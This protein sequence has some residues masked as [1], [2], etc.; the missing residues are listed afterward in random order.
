MASVNEYLK[1]LLYQYDCV[2]VPEL[3]AFLTHYQSASFTESSS[4][5][6]PPASALP[7]TRLCGWTMGFWQTT[8]CCTS[9]SPARARNGTS[10]CL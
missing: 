4:Q 3:G 1:K 2:V 7:L 6:L 8:S 5:Y 10:A 9:R